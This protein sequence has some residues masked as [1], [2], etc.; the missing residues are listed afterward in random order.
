MYITGWLTLIGDDW[1]LHNEY[2]K[3]S[4]PATISE[5]RTPIGKGKMQDGSRYFPQTEIYSQRK[6]LSSVNDLCNFFKTADLRIM[7]HESYPSQKELQLLS[8]LS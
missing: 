6:S 7:N 8:H 3:T 4:L 1:S 2:C 5:R